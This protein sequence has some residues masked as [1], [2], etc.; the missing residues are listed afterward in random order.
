MLDSRPDSALFSLS[1]QGRGQGEG[2]TLYL[3]LHR[4]T[5]GDS[6]TYGRLVAERVVFRIHAVQRMFE[7]GITEADVRAILAAGETIEEYPDD[8]PYPSRLVLGWCLGRPLHLVVADDVEAHE[9]IVITV[10]DPDP[11]LWEAGLRRR[12]RPWNV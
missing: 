4:L 10:Y 6:G 7:R 9:I 11:R 8:T 3:A 1:P 5:P 12:R 2:P